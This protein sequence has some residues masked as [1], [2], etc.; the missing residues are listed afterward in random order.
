MLKIII[1]S[2]QQQEKLDH[3]G[4]P[5]EFGRGPPGGLPRI[6]LQDKYVSRDQLRVQEHAGGL[7]HI[8][9]LSQGK[10]VRMPDGSDLAIGGVGIFAVPLTLS[11]GLTQITIQ[12][13][14]GSESDGPDEPLQDS[15]FLTIAQP[16]LAQRQNEELRSLAKLHEQGG[17]PTAEQLTQWLEI[18]IALQNST[19]G[20]S[21]L[22]T[23]AAQ[24]VVDLV[25]LDVGIVVL[26][27]DGRWHMV[28]GHTTDD[29]R[30]MRFSRTLVKHVAR[31][32]RTFYQDP[33]TVGENAE[34]LADVDAAVVSPIFG[35]RNDI[36]GVLYGAR[37]V[38][39]HQ[40]EPVTALHAQLVQLLATA[41]SAA[42]ARTTAVRT[43]VQFEQFFSPQ[44]VSELERNPN[45]LEGRDQLVT[46]LVSDLRG[47]TRLSETMGASVS[48]ALI[49]DMMEHM[50]DR[51]VDQGGVI[52]DYAGDGILAMWNAPVEQT[53][54]AV[55]AARA[56]L[57]MQAQMP[58]LNERWQ[59]T[60]GGPLALGIGLNT[61]AA[62]V[63]N[64]G[65]PRKF[66]YGPHGHTV[67]LAARVQ[68]A[69]KRL[70]SH[71]LITPATR[72]LLPPRFITR[73]AG[74]VALAGV[75]DEVTLFA[76]EAEV[77]ND[78]TAPLK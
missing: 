48:C 57:A 11:V 10:P 13:I 29:R 46:V 2:P 73:A 41:V 65:S 60:V 55:R 62:Q 15:G 3:P 77:S 51:I 43:R 19:V 14:A 40:P 8:E 36:V 64:T 56:A 18:V 54:H 30:S 70:G 66:K 31:E 16:A 58:G 67:N 45:L 6:I 25:G 9:N 33:N 17:V 50:S 34:S 37:S 44:L 1:N 71:L 59:A 32:R 47:F 4:G 21:E 12:R 26:L 74:E 35:L 5:L 7:L 20:L 42:I 53:D 24:A 75:K 76:L 68:D 27:Q 69:T 52:V 38:N 28:A 63:G 22:Y 49:R 61:G 78:S 72:A 23:Q 39:F